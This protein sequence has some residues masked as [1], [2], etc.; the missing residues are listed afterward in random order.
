MRS[1]RMRRELRTR[2]RIVT[3][4]LPSMFG[5]RDSR[6]TTCGCCSFSSAASSIVM[7]RSSSGMNDDSTFSVVVLP[8]AGTARDHDVD[9][10]AHAG[11]EE[12]RRSPSSSCRTPPGHRPGRG[13]RRTSGSSARV[14]RSPA[15]GSSRSHA[16]RRADGRRRR[17]RPRPLGG[18]P[19]PRSC[20]SCAA[21]VTRRG[22]SCRSRTA[23]RRAPRRSCPSC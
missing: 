21:A 4:P 20:R 13:R 5:G 10:A 12:L 2:S 18:R 16:S 9:A 22:T 7:M 23:C 15:A 1:G 6:R 8:G 19:C 17:A 11:V 14:R 3:S